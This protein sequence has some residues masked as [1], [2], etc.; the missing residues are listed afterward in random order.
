MSGT[1]EHLEHAENAGHGQ[2]GTDPFTMRVAMT[3]AIIAAILAA[4]S[5][6]GHRKH[7]EALQKQ[8]DANRLHTEAAAF[9]VDSSNAYAYYQAKRARVEQA[10]YAIKFTKLLASA[11]NSDEL[12]RA[13]VEGWQKYIQK[14]SNKKEDVKVDEAGFPLKTASG[15][16]DNSPGALLVYGDQYK[17]LA[18]ERSKE[19]DKSHKEYEHVHHQADGL[20]FA[21]LAVE[22]GL[23]LCTIS[24]LTRKREFWLGGILA[25]LVGVG[26]ASYALFAIH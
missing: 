9:K 13:E 12:R 23:V 2:H 11:P 25:A 15:E 21:H 5:L 16:E 14:N 18:I 10:G 6:I 19:A 1:H 17:R 8:G 3:M 7:N 26:V 24:V 20:D 22:L 4:V